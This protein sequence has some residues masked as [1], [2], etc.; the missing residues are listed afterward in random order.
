VLANTGNGVRDQE[1]NGD[2]DMVENSKYSAQN[3]NRHITKIESL[4][5][6]QALEILQQ[7]L[8][9]C[10]Q[11]RLKVSIS[12]LYHAGNQ[13]TIIVLENVNFVAGNLVLVSVDNGG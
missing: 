5:P 13:N 4:M 8:R 3:V 11:A 2:H 1:N 9:E 10:Q 7:A 6:E 12:S